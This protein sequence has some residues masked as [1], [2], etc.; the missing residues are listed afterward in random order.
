LPAAGR[1]CCR[2]GG[3]IPAPAG[4]LAISASAGM[5]AEG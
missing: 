3:M 2:H 4:A 5:K 1:G